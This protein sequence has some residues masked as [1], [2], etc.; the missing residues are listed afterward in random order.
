MSQTASYTS[1]KLTKR[2]ELRPKKVTKK[3]AK[4]VLDRQYLYM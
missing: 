4:K 3:L 1:A 2:I